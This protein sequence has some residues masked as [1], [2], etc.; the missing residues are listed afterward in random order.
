MRECSL[1]IGIVTYRS[2]DEVV[3]RLL[4]SLVA[5]VRG[6]TAQ[7]AMDVAIQVVCNDD[8]AARFRALSALVDDL[9]ES[10]PQCLRCELVTGHG[11][12]G[13]GA[14][15]NL[16]I[17]RSSADYHLVL[18][19]DVELTLAGPL[20]AERKITLLASGA[21]L[22]RHRAD[23]RPL[24]GGGS[25]RRRGCCPPLRALIRSGTSET[26]RRRGRYFT[27]DSLPS[28]VRPIDLATAD[29]MWLRPAPCTGGR[30]RVRRRDSLFT[31]TTTFRGGSP[32]MAIYEVRGSESAPC[33]IPRGAG[34]ADRP[35]RS[36]RYPVLQFLWVAYPVAC[37]AADFR[38]SCV[39]GPGKKSDGPAA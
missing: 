6:A 19:P 13:Y 3:R 31:K 29:Y 18:N 27:G 32:N 21:A 8:E 7:T 11:N 12:I 16:A 5:A 33:E 34:R 22:L 30:R 28:R 26:G 17:R 23:V 9:A 4:E 39:G 10:A 37:A 25:N 1:S 2:A 35:L 36:F 38:R 15:Q 20:L 24:S 14:A